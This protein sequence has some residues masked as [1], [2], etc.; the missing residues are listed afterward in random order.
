[1][2]WYAPIIASR[3]SAPGSEKDCSSARF[4]VDLLDLYNMQNGGLLPQEPFIN[5][6]RL[7]KCFSTR[8]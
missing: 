3:D 6:E 5:L 2:L 4:R 8:G 7:R 1:M